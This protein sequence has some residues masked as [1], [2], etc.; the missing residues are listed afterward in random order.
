MRRTVVNAIIGVVFLIGLLVG[1]A[2]QPR[3][4]SAAVGPVHSCGLVEDPSGQP[5]NVLVLFDSS[6]GEIWATRKKAA[7]VEI[8]CESELSPG[9]VRRLESSKTCPTFESGGVGKLPPITTADLQLVA[10]TRI[11]LDAE[12]C[13]R[14]LDE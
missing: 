3:Q 9:S 8:P 4:V 10:G 2:L 11:P 13:R 1:I 14:R 5:K 12:R 6:S 7:F